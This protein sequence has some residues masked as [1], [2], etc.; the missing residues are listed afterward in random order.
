M[1]D[2]YNGFEPLFKDVSIN[3][4][5]IPLD[6]SHYEDKIKNHIVIVD[7]RDRDCLVHPNINEYSITFN[8][9]F[10]NVVSIEVVN[11]C[12]P[13]T[14]TNDSPNDYIIMKI[15]QVDI[16]KSNNQSVSYTHL[17]LPTKRIV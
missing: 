10:Q 3:K 7:S 11:L 2:I 6:K 1:S 4:N 12:V 8:E 17:T 5:I 13:F 16:Y 15:K 9:A 14:S